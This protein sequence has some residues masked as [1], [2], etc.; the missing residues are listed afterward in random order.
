MSAEIF[1]QARHRSQMSC[2]PFRTWTD[3]GKNCPGT[4]IECEAA[5]NDVFYGR[6]PDESA[7]LL[8]GLRRGYGRP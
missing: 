4:P 7:A 3:P 1:L 5:G 8:R 2:L 6:Y